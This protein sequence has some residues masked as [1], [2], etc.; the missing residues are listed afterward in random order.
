MFRSP[1]RV[2]QRLSEES[3]DSVLEKALR[4]VLALNGED[5]FPYAL[6]INFYYDKTAKK[7][8]FHCGKVGY[9]LDCINANKKAS[10]TAQDQGE[11]R[12]GEWWLTF[13]SVI[14]FG[15]VEPVTDKAVVERISRKLSDKFT[16]DKAYVDK[17]V[18]KYLDSTV[19]LVFSIM[20]MTG[21]TVREK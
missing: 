10:F 7:I 20:H 15:E 18:E 4:G 12:D 17:E 11:R 21:K 16:S 9:K 5:G 1:L 19:L 14:A 8:Y 6:P 3:C 2:N 13:Q